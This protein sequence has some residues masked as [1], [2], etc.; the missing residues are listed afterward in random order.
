MTKVQTL[1][2]CVIFG[3]GNQEVPPRIDFER[4]D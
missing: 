4:P 1:V 3:A 2:F